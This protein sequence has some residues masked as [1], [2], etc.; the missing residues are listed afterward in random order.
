MQEIEMIAPPPPPSVGIPRT[1]SEASA[2]VQ[3]DFFL[4][5]FWSFWLFF[6]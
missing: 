2:R 4:F 1:S 3:V 5:F 6:Q